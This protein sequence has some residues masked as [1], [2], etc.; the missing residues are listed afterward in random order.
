MW[1]EWNNQKI[2]SLDFG[3]LVQITYGAHYYCIVRDLAWC[4]CCWFLHFSKLKLL[5][6]NIFTCANLRM[7]KCWLEWDNMHT[8]NLFI[9]RVLHLNCY[10]TRSVSMGFKRSRARSSLFYRTK[11]KIMYPKAFEI[12]NRKKTNTKEM[13][14]PFSL[15][16]FTT[17]THTHTNI[18]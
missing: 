8:N 2:A 3:A 1:I 11:T 14:N 16:L 18:L 13:Y 12:K 7:E 15:C 17:L 9:I 5:A 6:N 10:L 4:F